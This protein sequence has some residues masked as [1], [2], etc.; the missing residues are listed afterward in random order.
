M[1][2]RDNGLVGIEWWGSERKCECKQC[3]EAD[4]GR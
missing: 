3:N 4:A 1:D 2:G